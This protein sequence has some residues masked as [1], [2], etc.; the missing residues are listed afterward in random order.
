[1]TDVT[2]IV[3]AAGEGTRIKANHRNKVAY[4]LANKP[5][6]SYTVDNL[7]RSGIKN[8]IVVIGY[9]QNSVKKVLG[10]Q[11]TY[12]I[13]KKQLGTGDAFK[14]G[15]KKVQSVT[16]NVISIYGDD[17]AF[18]TPEVIRQ[19]IKHHQKKHSDVTFLTLIKKDPTGLGR[20]IRNSKGNVT[21]IVEEKNTTTEEKKIIEIN[22]GFYC[23][24]RPFIDQAIKKVQ[25]NPIS[26]EYYLTDIIEIATKDNKKVEALL[27]KDKSVWYGVNTNEQFKTADKLMREKIK[28]E[29]N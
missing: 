9:A 7:K 21:A 12:A 29:E 4:K 16:P 17:S 25:K 5:M 20:V 18:F 15:L 22:T 3:L 24:S 27:W 14:T 11:V 2:A 6:I 10:N 19:L 28:H 8:I 26:Q 1:M 13:Q 23:F